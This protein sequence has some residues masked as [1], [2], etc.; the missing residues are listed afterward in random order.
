MS[1]TPSSF[2]ISRSAQHVLLRAST[3]SLRLPLLLFL[4]LLPLASSKKPGAKR[5]PGSDPNVDRRSTSDSVSRFFFVAKLVYVLVF[6]PI[7]IY[8]VWSVV[9]DPAVPVIARAVVKIAKR[10]VLGFL[11]RAEDVD[12]ENYS[13]GR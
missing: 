6:A 12:L 11:W 10:K 4:F 7:L 1:T 2:S 9:R 5:R 8:F 3:R 13:K